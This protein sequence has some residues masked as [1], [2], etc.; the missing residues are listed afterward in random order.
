M[1]HSRR[2]QDARLALHAA[3]W[4]AA[5]SFLAMSL[6]E[7]IFF[8]FDLY[9]L[10]TLLAASGGNLPVAELAWLPA[11]CAVIGFVAGPAVAGAPP[12]HPAAGIP[13]RRAGS[14]APRG[15]TGLQR[16]SRSLA[17]L[18]RSVRFPGVA[19]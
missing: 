5:C 16:H 8:L 18:A 10:G 19:P 12:D 6:F 2:R 4:G 13:R 11:L 9:G 1:D 17:R 15:R 3:L 14:I 7:A